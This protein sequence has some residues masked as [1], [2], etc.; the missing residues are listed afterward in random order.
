MVSEVQHYPNLPTMQTMRTGR[1]GCP[2]KVEFCHKIR[3][4][5]AKVGS[6]H[7]FFS[8]TIH[9]LKFVDIL[10]SFSHFS[11]DR[12]PQCPGGERELATVVL[13]EGGVE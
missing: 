10:G 2:S 8:K 7:L 1:E 3:S 12:F 4:C 11:G 6:V 9:L 13:G 5:K